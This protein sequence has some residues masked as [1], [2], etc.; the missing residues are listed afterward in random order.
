MNGITLISHE[1]TVKMLAGVVVIEGLR[2]AGESASKLVHSCG[3]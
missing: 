2:G 3:W 1:V